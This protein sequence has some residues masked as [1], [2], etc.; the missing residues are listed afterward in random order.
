[1]R[2]VWYTI[3]KL[4]FFFGSLFFI[5]DKIMVPNK[6]GEKFVEKFFF[7][8]IIQSFLLP[9]RVWTLL[10]HT[11][12]TPDELFSLKKIGLVL[13]VTIFFT[14]GKW[15]KLT[16]FVLYSKSAILFFFL[17]YFDLRTL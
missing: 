15:R 10:Y 12:K 17:F 13:N 11:E 7:F 4:L 3:G 6:K 2:G 5:F 14:F 1:L 8:K 16:F 9:E